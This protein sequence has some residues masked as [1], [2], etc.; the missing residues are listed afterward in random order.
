MED[1]L[2]FLCRIVNNEF[3]RRQDFMLDYDEERGKTTCYLEVQGDNI[4]AECYINVYNS[5]SDNAELIVHNCPQLSEETEKIIG[6]KVAN[7]EKEKIYYLGNERAHFFVAL[8][9]K[10]EPEKVIQVLKSLL[11]EIFI[12]RVFML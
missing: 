3:I 9:N 2:Y 10:K 1:N 8:F 12:T 4:I 6:E 5:G 11:N 7:I